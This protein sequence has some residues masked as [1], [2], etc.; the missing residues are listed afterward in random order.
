MILCKLQNSPQKMIP[1]AMTLLAVGLAILVVGAS[2][3]MLV[4]SFLNLGSNDFLH[5]FC[6]GL[7]LT[8]EIG[9]VILVAAAAT[10]KYISS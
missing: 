8:L 10:R 3:P 5:G 4:P 9:G 1:F 7:G 2:W 6:F